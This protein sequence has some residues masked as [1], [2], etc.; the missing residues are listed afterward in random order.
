MLTLQ[1]RLTIFAMWLD[2][3]KVSFASGRLELNEALIRMARVEGLDAARPSLG[4][5]NNWFSGHVKKTSASGRTFLMEA[6]RV[7]AEK[8]GRAFA[9]QYMDIDGTRLVTQFGLDLS[10]VVGRLKNP[11][12]AMLHPRNVFQSSTNQGER[13]KHYI[14]TLPSRLEKTF[15]LFHR[16]SFR[17]GSLV[18]NVFRIGS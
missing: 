1:D 4:T 15:F 18:R 2:L 6:L 3:D 7:L 16:H 8:R 14:D 5:L 12:A 11:P 9:E 13:T 10:T 17:I